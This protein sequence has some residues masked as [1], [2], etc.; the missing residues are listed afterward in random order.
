MCSLE[1]W[2]CP[3]NFFTGFTLC[4]SGFPAFI[5]DTN[6]PS[7]D[8]NALAV[9]EIGSVF[10]KDFI[11]L[12]LERGKGGREGEKH[13]CVVASHTPPTGEVAGNPGLCPDWESNW[14]P[15]GSQ[16]G[17]QS[18]EPHQPGLFS[19][20]NYF[21]LQMQHDVCNYTPAVGF[22]GCCSPFF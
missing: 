16:A 1:T 4:T 22:S 9:R 15:C 21:R 6:V 20:S 5:G 2:M 10:F 12:F 7:L 17:I 18:T 8:T 13:Q 11:Y 3:H 19:I 14:R